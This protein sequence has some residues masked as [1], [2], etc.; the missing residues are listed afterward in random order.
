MACDDDIRFIRVAPRARVKARS[1]KASKITAARRL[2]RIR[3]GGIVAALQTFLQAFPNSACFSASIS[4]ESFGV[5]VEFQGVARVPNHKRCVSKPTSFCLI[6]DSVAPH[7]AAS[8]RTRS[9]LARDC[10][11]GGRRGTFH[12]SG[13]GEGSG[14][15][16]RY[17]HRE[18]EHS[19]NSDYWKEK[20]RQKSALSISPRGREVLYIYLSGQI[21]RP[22][23]VRTGRGEGH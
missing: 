16:E 19:K 2:M 4:K 9:R 11:A 1:S 20:F 5:F 14:L 13:F 15:V 3:H 23:P 12:D 6:P 17:G 18:I 22:L 10:V 21:A 7:S 8:R